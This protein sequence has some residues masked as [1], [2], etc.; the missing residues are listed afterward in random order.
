MRWLF[1]V[2]LLLQFFLPSAVQAQSCTTPFINNVAPGEVI[3]LSKMS[4][5]YLMALQG[6]CFYSPK[7]TKAYSEV[8]LSGLKPA[9]EPL[10]HKSILFKGDLAMKIPPVADDY[11]ISLKV[12]NH[13]YL[14]V[15]LGL[16]VKLPF[17]IFEAALQNFY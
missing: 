7:G 8:E 16:D 15:D 13:A 17:G 4:A 5:P 12:I 9:F 11:V 14:G 6:K 3:L 10:I 2:Y 1:V